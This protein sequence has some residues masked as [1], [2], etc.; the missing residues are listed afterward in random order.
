MA[1]DHDCG[2]QVLG[3]EQ[4]SAG[5]AETLAF[6]ERWKHSPGLRADKS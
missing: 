6:V 4:I 1:A 3:L 5:I 2:N